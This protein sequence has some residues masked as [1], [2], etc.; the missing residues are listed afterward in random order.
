MKF[1]MLIAAVLC[2]VGWSS[3]SQNC[4]CTDIYTSVDDN[5]EGVVSPQMLI[6]NEAECDPNLYTILLMDEN[7]DPLVDENG[8]ALPADEFRCNHVGQTIMA[9][10]VG[11]EPTCMASVFI[12]DK[13]APTCMALAD[14]TLSCAEDIDPELVR[15]DTLV[16][17]AGDIGGPPPGPPSLYRETINSPT[18]GRIRNV[19]LYVDADFEDLSGLSLFFFSPDGT[20]YRMLNQAA[21][22]AGEDDLD[23]TF[24][25]NGS[26]FDCTALTGS[27]QPEVAD[28]TDLNNTDKMG[29]WE[30]VARD[31]N[32]APFGF[33]NEAFMVIEYDLLPIGEDNCSYTITHSDDR[34]GLNACNIGTVI[35]TFT[36]SDQAGRSDQCQQMIELEN[37]EVPPYT[38]EWP[39]D[40]I[41]NCNDS[42]DLS[43][44]D[45]GSGRPIVNNL[46]CSMAAASLINEEIYDENSPGCITILRFWR[47]RDWC[48]NV[49]MDIPSPQEIKVMDFDSPELTCPNDTT[50]SVGDNCQL[51]LTDRIPPP[52]VTDNCDP[53]PT[54]T[55]R[56]LD[57][58]GMELTDITA[59]GLGDYTIEYTASDD[60]GNDTTCTIS[61]TLIDAV[62]PQAIC[63]GNT[64]ITLD[65]TGQA[66]LFYTTIEDGSMD[67]C[68][69]DSIRISR[70]SMNFFE[71]L[72]YDCDDIYAPVDG[73]MAVWD[74]SGNMSIC[75]F[76]VFVDDK[77]EPEIV[78]C[79][80][81]LSIRCW[82]DITD[83]TRTGLPTATD[84][85]DSLVFTFSDDDSGLDACG[86][87][88]VIR[89][90]TVTD[91]A[92]LTTSCQQVITVAP[93]TNI[94][95]AFPQDTTVECE[96]NSGQN[97]TGIPV[98]MNDS[99]S[100]YSIRLVMDVASGSC[101]DGDR[102][103]ERSWRVEHNC[104]TDLFFEDT[105]IIGII[106]TTPPA[107]DSCPP[108]MTVSVGP[109]NVDLM[110][111]ATDN[112]DSLSITNNAL[113][114][115][116]QGNGMDDASGTYPEGV[117]DIRFIASDGCGNFDT[118]DVQVTVENNF[119]LALSSDDISALD[120][121]DPGDT[122]QFRIT[123]D[124]EG[125][126]DAF[127]ID[128]IQE[129]ADGFVFSSL[130]N[131][132]WSLMGSDLRT[133]IDGPL[134]S[135]AQTTVD[136]FLILDS[137]YDGLC[138][139]SSV[140]IEDASDL[141]GGTTATDRD[142]TPNN[143]DP[144]EDDYDE[145]STVSNEN[146]CD[147]EASECADD[148]G[149][150]DFTLSDYDDN[151]YKGAQ[152][153]DV[154][155]HETE[156][157][158][159]ADANP[160]AGVYTTSG[161]TLFAR[162]EDASISGCYGVRELYLTTFCSTPSFMDVPADITV[163]CDDTYSFG[164]D[165]TFS[166]TCGAMLTIQDDSIPGNCT[167]EFQL[168]RTWTAMNDCG[169]SVDTSQTINVVDN[170][171][172]VI[173]DVFDVT[174]DEGDFVTL[175]ATV[176]D[177][178]A[179][180]DSV[181]IV[182]DAPVGNGMEDASG[183]Y[184]VGDTDVTFTATDPCG[185]S[186]SVIVTVTVL[187]M[188]QALTG[189]TTI[190][191][192]ESDFIR[193]TPEDLDRNS[194]GDGLTFY[195]SQ[196]D[197]D[198]ADIGNNSVLFMVED[199]QGSRDTA[200]LNL[201]ILPYGL[202]WTVNDQ[203]LSLDENGNRELEPED[204]IQN[205]NLHCTAQ[206]NWVI[207]PKSLDCTMAE[208][209]VEILIQITTLDNELL[210]ETTD[211]WR[212]TDPF[213]ACTL[214]STAMIAGS[215]LM[216][217]G[218]AM[219]DVEL[220]II[221]SGMVMSDEDGH[222]EK[223]DLPTDRSYALIPHY[224]GASYRDGLSTLDLLRIR[225]HILQLQEF[226]SPYEWIAADV[227]RSGSVTS[228]DMVLIRQIILRLM[229][230]FPDC[231][232]WDFVPAD[233]D[234]SAD[235]NPFYSTFPREIFIDNLRGNSMEND[236]VSI[237]MGDVNNSISILSPEDRSD[238]ILVE[239]DHGIYEQG[240]Y[241]GQHYVQIKKMN[242]ELFGMQFAVQLPLDARP[243][244]MVGKLEGLSPSNFRYDDKKAILYFSWENTDGVRINE[245]TTILRIDFEE[246]T[247]SE[248]NISLSEGHLK[249]EA[250]G[251][252][253]RVYALDLR[254]SK[255]GEN[256][257]KALVLY[258]NKPNPV[259]GSTFIGFEIPVTTTD[260]SER[261]GG[262]VILDIMD[263]LG[264]LVYSDSGIF[265]SGYGEFLVNTKKLEMNGLYYYRIQ[266]N[267]HSL[268]KKMITIR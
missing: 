107:I 214:S 15:F 218:T 14:I 74:E 242:E 66:K 65:G 141:S 122:V 17:P 187:P 222:F 123:I 28:L 231:P 6:A 12:D 10:L 109:D 81:D 82:E 158:A 265:S 201:R 99:C 85:C 203:E 79:A 210:F 238:D 108:D 232:K 49:V 94:V 134:V 77:D 60:C 111:T 151:V 194:T 217:D 126:V 266:Y 46:S 25:S 166:D 11:P 83:T 264:N 43:A 213:G 189:D 52:S 206:F 157:D 125:D 162:I 268:S 19:S 131:P 31:L 44:T 243:R 116:G 106:D 71:C 170:T 255:N 50:M 236:F 226:S 103:I 176:S 70:D 198:C 98:V 155:Y 154:S 90:H 168:I 220:E 1:K 120:E 91:G 261:E 161:D 240:K 48:S 136:L 102:Q 18:P 228:Y 22:C 219:K 54:V 245:K 26:A 20:R 186:A 178:C 196:T 41:Y 234:F 32:D 29:D 139:S 221:G 165:P 63:D 197:F 223:D 80:D 181:D 202:P 237:K 42:Y 212:V 24:D 172:P 104:R 138:I 30:L 3:Y 195:L 249:A 179:P 97:S 95:V 140:E 246:N 21:S 148:Q 177:N 235:P 164:P 16:F 89:T 57:D 241:N 257:T 53:S 61:L 88:D 216:E 27:V 193:I 225:Q 112:C 13:T 39:S 248:T 130:L 267:G 4:A 36:I 227:N 135:L 68:G 147:F 132:D 175:V 59:L 67:N 259:I 207:E 150:A 72:I 47:V 180:S 258:Q 87:G 233:F 93:V 56:V 118:C 96:S 209:D 137:G 86:L 124:N 191:M 244:I 40:T 115:Y 253:N 142:S 76:T 167:Q 128:I 69:I 247:L 146:L 256:S 2:C 73:W 184:P 171:A 143:G 92:G 78:Q 9:S 45:E 119:D 5:G 101:V 183:V 121:Y 153:V 129:L 160:V 105:Q 192:G 199:S 188:L 208:Q 229:E 169:N 62:N 156:A 262:E 211:S 55:T 254:P 152:A 33:M 75:D 58:S 263:P 250:Y 100:N 200:E 144:S 34:S 163:S 252:N 8:M 215:I 173:S 84:N 224:E 239:L 159:D 145:S 113:T 117:Y 149:E 110:V 182:N 260:G 51:D 204:L 185:N 190:T 230:E 38:V 205:P 127:D 114:D 23:V 251:T 64:T 174:V 37:N 133:T 7:G 35:R